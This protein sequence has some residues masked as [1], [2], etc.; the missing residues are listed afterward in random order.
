MKTGALLA[1]FGRSLRFDESFVLPVEKSRKNFIQ[2]QFFHGG[3]SSAS[4]FTLF[5]LISDILNVR[6]DDLA[7]KYLPTC[8]RWAACK[9]CVQLV[10]QQKI[11]KWCIQS[12]GSNVQ[13]QLCNTT[14]CVHLCM[15]VC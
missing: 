7:F 11:N 12:E 13:V 6:W 4:D 5:P 15:H 1:V 9:F 10:L 14:K 2:S 3:C 8:Q